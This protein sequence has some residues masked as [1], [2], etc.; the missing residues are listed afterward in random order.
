M[1]IYHLTLQNMPEI[2]ESPESPE[3]EVR[4]AQVRD[5]A[6]ETLED[7]AARSARHHHSLIPD[8]TVYFAPDLDDPAVERCVERCIEA[9]E[10]RAR[11]RERARGDG[12]REDKKRPLRRRD[13]RSIRKNQIHKL[14]SDRRRYTRESPGK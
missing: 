6:T 2:N 5:G 10:R 13:G 7:P 1:S 4:S 9:D 11:K 3:V 14:L 8:P 12:M